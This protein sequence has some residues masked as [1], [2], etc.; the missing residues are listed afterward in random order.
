MPSGHTYRRFQVGTGFMLLFC[1][2]LTLGMGGAGLW[3]GIG[4]F[5]VAALQFVHHCAGGGGTTHRNEPLLDR[6]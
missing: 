5:A 2:S 3:V 4:T 1:G 6:A